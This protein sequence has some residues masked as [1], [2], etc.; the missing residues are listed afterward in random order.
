MIS[1]FNLRAYF[2]PLNKIYLV[3]NLLVNGDAIIVT[4][5]E[6]NF[7][8]RLDKPDD[9]FFK[10][11]F[12]LLQSTGLVDKNGK[13]IFEGDIVIDVNDKTK[14][15]VFYRE[16]GACFSLE[17]LDTEDFDCRDFGEIQYEGIEQNLKVI[18]N[19]YENPELLIKKE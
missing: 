1:R 13:E 4:D 8:D 10:D 16:I 19:I 9:R 17:F 12:I 15:K 2:M 7:I 6:G 11:E 3:F 14:Y 18:G 5:E